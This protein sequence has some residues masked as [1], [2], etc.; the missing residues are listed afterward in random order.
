MYRHP[1]ST[2]E[3]ENMME[4]IVHAH[5][6]LTGCCRLYTYCIWVDNLPV[7]D[8]FMIRI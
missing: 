2:L 3:N 7:Y 4:N 6:F 1:L 8:M 5:K